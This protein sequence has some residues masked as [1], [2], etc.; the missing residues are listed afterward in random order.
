MGQSP[1]SSI[2]LGR[3]K[4]META[5]NGVHVLD[6]SQMMLGPWGTQF[7]G[8]YGADVIKVERPGVGEWER[9]LRAMGRLVRDGNS[10][11]FHA[12]NRNKRSIAVDL[13][14]PEGI[15]VILDLIPKIDVVVENYRPGVMDRL[16][17]GYETLSAINPALVY[18]SGSGYGAAGPYASRPGQDLII[19]AI[20]GL[21]ANT[22]RRDDLPVPLGSA[23]V[24]ASTALMLALHVMIA[25]HYRTVSGKGQKVEVNLFNTAIAVQCQELSAFMNLG[26][27]WQR[28][29]SGIAQA[30]LAAP[31]G[32]YPTQDG[33]VAIAM[34]SLAR[35]GE[36]LDLPE[37]AQYEDPHAAFENRDLV[38]SLLEKK[39]AQMKRQD[40]LDRLL[41]ADI[42]CGPVQ[43]FE[44]LVKDPQAAWNDMFVDVEHPD[45]GTLRLVGYP[46][47]LSATPAS[48]RYPPPRVGEHTEEVLRGLGIEAAR[49]EDLRK[50]GVIG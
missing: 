6:F 24:D 37:L 14:S 29:E 13:K 40:L 28:S 42:W 50:K 1:L 2:I 4:R 26:A 15:A 46:G 34:A 8:D 5:L 11:F 19:Q 21:A 25:L 18:A 43:D 33:H 41:A 30:W 7:L 20:S 22:G 45:A 48:V 35:L 17:L 10:A 3:V 31:Y 39:T 36:L 12:M 23:I 47:R 38:K 9:G 16:G 32:I 27:R 44:E 49:I